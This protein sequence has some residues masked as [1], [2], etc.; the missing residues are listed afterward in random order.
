MCIGDGPTEG[1]PTVRGGRSYWNAL[2]RSNVMIK[3]PGTPEGAR[4]IEQS[5]YAG[6]NVNVT[7]L[8]A[9]E[10]YETVAEAY[11]RGLERRHQRRQRPGPDHA[12][13]AEAAGAPPHD[14]PAQRVCRALS[15]HDRTGTPGLAVVPHRA[16]VAPVV[17]P[18]PRLRQA[19]PPVD[20]LAAGPAAPCVGAGAAGGGERP[21]GG[22]A[23]GRFRCGQRAKGQR[24]EGS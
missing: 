23:G 9:V 11:L 14:L 13:V 5:I 16:P 19:R 12:H 3:I 2:D 10:A 20:D 17:A 1:R 8:F 6:I 7:L 15:A 21:M 4:A 18:G 24:A 22:R